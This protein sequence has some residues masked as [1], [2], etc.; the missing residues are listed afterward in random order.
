MKPS[1][2]KTKR[3]E[4][5]TPESR[6]RRSNQ[7]AE[8]GLPA[9]L[10]ASEHDGVRI[11]FIRFTEGDA[12]KGFAPGYHFQILDTRGAPA[13]HINF[14]VGDSD[15]VR[16]CAGH[17]GFAVHP[18]HRGRGIAAKAC[19]ALAP[20]VAEVAGSVILTADPDNIPSQKTIRKIGATAIDEIIVPKTDPHYAAGSRRKRRFHWAPSPPPPPHSSS[21]EEGLRR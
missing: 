7:P 16:L 20:F 3:R 5:R 4:S 8:P 21:Q 14:R 13:G 19:L 15:H 18:E 2:E 6:K 9:P 17:I 10:E 11:R 1:N 12:T